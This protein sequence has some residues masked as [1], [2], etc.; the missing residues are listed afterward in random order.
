MD[1]PVVFIHEIDAEVVELVT[2]GPP[3]PTT[4]PDRFHRMTG[5]EP[6]GDIDIVDVLLDEVIARERYPILPGADQVIRRLR[7]DRLLPEHVADAERDS[8]CVEPAQLLLDGNGLVRLATFELMSHLGAG[9]NDQALLLGKLP[10]GD[11]APA[12]GRID[13]DGLLDEDVLA[14]LDRRFEVERA[15]QRSRCH[16]ND[17]H[18][19]F[20]QLAIAVGPAKA[21][22]GRDVEL[23]ARSD[24]SGLEVV[25]GGGDLNVE[26]KNLSRL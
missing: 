26:A 21:F 12:A 20:E 2:G 1:V 14:R 8:A 19:G 7:V 17:L 23:L 11:D 16:Q 5:H 24:C 22:I 6:V 3:V 9:C 18:V 15:K 10:R 13:G 25:G 4:E